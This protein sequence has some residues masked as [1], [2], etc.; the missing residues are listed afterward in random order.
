[1]VRQVDEM[2]AGIKKYQEITH[3]DQEGMDDKHREELILKYAPLIKY[4]ANRIATRLPMH[5]DIQDLINSGVLG[6]MDAIEKFD[7]S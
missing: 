3:A 7:L 6:L 5:I 1:M 4:I 2:N